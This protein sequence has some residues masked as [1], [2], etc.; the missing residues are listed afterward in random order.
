MNIKKFIICSIC[1]MSIVTLYG[2]QV[3][4]SLTQIK[5]SKLHIEPNPLNIKVE[6]T[7]QV[8]IVGLDQNG[9]SDR[10]RSIFFVSVAG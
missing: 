2:Q 10:R 9:E 3:N 1:F 8:Q 6:D 7:Q 4:D 5:A